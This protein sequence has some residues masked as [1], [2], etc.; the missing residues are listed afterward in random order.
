[1]H[2]TQTA[3]E[4]SA[5]AFRLEQMAVTSEILA[6]L[7]DLNEILQ[8]I[9]V[10]ARELT[11]AE[12]AAITTFDEDGGIERFVFTGMDEARARRLG[13][14]PAGRGLLGELA[15]SDRP[16]MLDNVREH[17]AFTGWPDGHP[18]MTSFLGVPIR[19]GGRAI[20]SLYLTHVEAG[21]PFT[22]LD[23]L[24][25]ATLA[26]QA[27][28]S[29]ATALAQDR[30]GRLFL[31]E[32]RERI[33]HD[34]HDGTIQALYAL[35]LEL[36]ALRGRSDVTSE[37]RES[38]A[39]GV[40]RIND[41]ISDI[42]TYITMLEAEAPAAQPELGRDLAFV[43]RQMVP[44]GT[45]AVVNITAAALQELSARESEDL[46]YIAREAL[47]NA[48]RHGSASKIAIDLRQS[49]YVTALTIQDNGV[50][51]D[52]ENVRSGLGTV[53]MRTRA[54]RLGGTITV[55]G[56]PGMGTTVRVEI[57]RRRDD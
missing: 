44:I 2:A 39:L 34:L 16:V 19:A 46:L 25:V 3:D 33:A 54:E 48:V 40:S 9:A 7:S 1:M 55:L 6:G 38:L 49:P 29:V 36:D 22:E 45:D 30:S 31:F 56:I 26:L 43:V 20:G 47:S 37:A 50:G 41:L 21:K 23:Q 12:Y 13:N 57:P 18:E 35:G 32:E 15:R 4:R 28:V 14:P 24:A 52:S 27:A 53:T 11:G 17:P 5:I 42:R 51:F 8:R 10:R